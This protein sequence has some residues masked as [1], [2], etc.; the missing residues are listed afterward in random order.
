VALGRPLNKWKLFIRDSTVSP[1]LEFA[2]EHNSKREALERAYDL[3][4]HFTA[5]RIV[6]PHGERIESDALE[7]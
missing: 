7:R 2:S 5:V 1:P 3:P 6:G 4:P